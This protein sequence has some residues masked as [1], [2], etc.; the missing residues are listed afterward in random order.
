MVF[1]FLITYLEILRG[2]YYTWFSNLRVVDGRD[3]ALRSAELFPTS[4]FV[5]SAGHQSFDWC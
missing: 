3:R 5:V 4:I 1:A 2:S